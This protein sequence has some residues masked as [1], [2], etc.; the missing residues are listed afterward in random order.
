MEK[1]IFESGVEL[2]WGDA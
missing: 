1:V 2:R